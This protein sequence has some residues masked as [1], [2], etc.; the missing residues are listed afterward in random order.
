MINMHSILRT[1]QNSYTYRIIAFGGKLGQN[2]TEI[3]Q[4]SCDNRKV[5]VQSSCYLHDL[6]I[7]IARCPYDDLAEVAKSLYANCKCR[8]IMCHTCSFLDSI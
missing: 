5:I 4:I 1:L 8:E 3:M 6:P 7:L 2:H